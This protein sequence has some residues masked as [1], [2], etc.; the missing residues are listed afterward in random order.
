MR[1][2]QASRS[3]KQTPLGGAPAASTSLAFT[4]RWRHTNIGMSIAIRPAR[5]RDVG[6]LARFYQAL[7]PRSRMQRFHGAVNQLPAA[8]VAR[9]AGNDGPDALTLLAV[10][11]GGAS[12]AIV[13]EARYFVLPDGRTAEFAVSV[14][15]AA[16]GIGLGRRLVQA[17]IREASAQ[18]IEFLRGDVMPE[19]DAMLALARARFRGNAQRQ[20]YTPAQH[21]ARD[22]AGAVAPVDATGARCD[23]RRI[24][25]ALR[26]RLKAVRPRWPAP[27]QRV[28]ARAA[29]ARRYAP[30]RARTPRSGP[31]SAIRPGRE[32]A[33]RRSEAWRGA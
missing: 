12:E 14:T 24:D 11:V 27:P 22:R 19:N 4:Q 32:T 9:F 17:L 6:A 5:P 31:A 16:Q 26:T 23:V 21:R 28:P 1:D 7:S 33:Q 3:T 10:L 30:P 25:A 15:D 13:G 18:G 8:T 20:R 2:L 29:E